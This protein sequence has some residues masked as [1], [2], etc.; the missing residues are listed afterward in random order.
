MKIIFLLI[1]SALPLSALC[2]QLFDS[3]SR[4]TVQGGIDPATLITFRYEHR[5]KEAIFKKE[6]YPFAE[7]SSSLTRFGIKNS[8]IKLGQRLPVWNNSRIK[9]ISGLNTSFGKV[10]TINFDSKKIALEG[11]ISLG[12]FWKRG[13]L[14]VTT[15]YE[16]ILATKLEHTQ[17]YRDRFYDHAKDGW[18]KSSGGSFQFGLEGGV[19]IKNTIDVYIEL[20]IPTTEKFN[21]VMGS[22]GHVNFGVSYRL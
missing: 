21:S 3:K 19:V 22:P 6:S 2:Q 15:S 20:K 8:E 7:F 17:Y 16:K 5:I 4:V 9:L 11:D 14:A 13:F 10:E 18:Y 1:F 12:P